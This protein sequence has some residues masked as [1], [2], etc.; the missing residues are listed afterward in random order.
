MPRGDRTGPMGMGPR[1][2]RGA[3][4]CNGFATP[5]F[6]N[7]VG[8]AGGFGGPFGRGRG[9]CRAFYAPGRPGWAGYGYPAYSDEKNAA[10]DEKAYLNHQADFFEDQ[11]RQIKKRMAALSEDAE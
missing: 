11:L 3:G 7:P 1:T 9:Y 4:F 5:G 2:G 6:T 8:F 10:S